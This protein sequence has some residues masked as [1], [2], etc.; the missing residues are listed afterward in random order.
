M[1]SSESYRLKSVSF[2]IQHGVTYV[3]FGNVKKYNSL[4]KRDFVKCERDTQ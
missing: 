3:N 1:I 4:N 2:L